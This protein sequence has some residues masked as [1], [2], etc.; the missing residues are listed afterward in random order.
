MYHGGRSAPLPGDETASDAVAPARAPSG[1][2]H[3]AAAGT[4]ARPHTGTG[5]S[6]SSGADRQAASSSV[7]WRVLFWSSGMPGPLVV[8]IVA[9]V[10]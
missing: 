2:G 5:P 3:P 8:D 10:M 1:G 9:L 7:R 6:S 4:K